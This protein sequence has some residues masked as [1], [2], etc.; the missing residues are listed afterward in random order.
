MAAINEHAGK[1]IK[2]GWKIRIV[3]MVGE[4]H[5][6]GKEGVVE[7]IDSSGQAFG[8]WGGIAIQPD[9]DNFEVLSKGAEG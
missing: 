8:S 9:R 7:H 2:V 1:E 5:Y 4:P 3:E 6:T